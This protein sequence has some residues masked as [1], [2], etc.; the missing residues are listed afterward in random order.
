MRTR[1]TPIIIEDASFVYEHEDFLADISAAN[2]TRQRSSTRK[3]EEEIPRVSFDFCLLS[4]EWSGEG[5][6]SPRGQGSQEEMFDGRHVPREEYIKR[7]L[8]RGH[9]EVLA[10]CIKY[11]CS[12]KLGHCLVP[13]KGTPAGDLV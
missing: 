1:G 2:P 9:Q 13:R 3:S 7:H 11:R 4:F 12:S 10:T 8:K 5:R 6:P